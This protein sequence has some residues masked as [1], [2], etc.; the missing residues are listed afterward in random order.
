M[1]MFPLL[2]FLSF[3]DR[4]N[5]GNASVAGMSKDLNLTTA[6]Y[7]TA[8]SVFY[9]TYIATEIPS[10]LIVRKIGPHYYMSILVLSRVLVTLF[11]G[12]VRSYW[13]LVLTRLLLGLFE[14]GFFPCQSLYITMTFKREEQA[15][16]QAY[17]YVC[18]CFS[19]AFGE[20][21]LL[22]VLPRSPNPVRYRDGAGF[23]S[24]RVSYL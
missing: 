11:S 4:S 9:A 6:Q 24:S 20:I 15:V 14:G 12:F 17:L 19:G 10:V 13:S 7:S 21:S 3:L 16:R 18:S 23:T 8:V 5:I 2:Y 22:L 1:P